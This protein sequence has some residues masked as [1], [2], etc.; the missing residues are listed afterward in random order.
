MNNDNTNTKEWLVAS[1]TFLFGL[2]M[3]IFGVSVAFYLLR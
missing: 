3:L 1:G 2:G